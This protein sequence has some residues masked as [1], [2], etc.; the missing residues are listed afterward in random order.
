MVLA[1]CGP[2]VA[3]SLIG[4]SSVPVGWR[5]CF[6]CG[7]I[8]CF[9]T[10]CLWKERVPRRGPIEEVFITDG[11][12]ESHV[13]IIV[14]DAVAHTQVWVCDRCWSLLFD[15][16]QV[17]PSDEPST[18]LALLIFLRLLLRVVCDWG[19]GAKVLTVMFSKHLMP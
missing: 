13:V 15:S 9:W 2:L 6:A 8:T 5:I 11:E 1:F 7:L 10:R 18:M 14:T 3:V 4:H 12:A 19:A 16:G 17:R